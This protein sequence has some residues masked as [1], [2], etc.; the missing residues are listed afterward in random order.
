MRS[1]A[2]H[3]AWLKVHY[4]AEFMA[5][6]L[7]A[8]QDD[9]D[10]VKILIEDARKILEL[11]I[12]PPDVMLSNYHFTPVLESG[13]VAGSRGCATVLV[14]LRGRGTVPSR[15]SSRPRQS[16]PFRDLYD[17]CRRIDKRVVNRRV[18]EAL[19]R[20]GSFDTI[21]KDR[22]SLLA[23]VP[24]A[25]EAAEQ[26]EANLNQ[27]SLFDMLADGKDDAFELIRVRGFTEKQQLTEEKSALGLLPVRP[28]L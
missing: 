10:K 23:S 24:R 27:V 16:E 18:L 15:R 3:T 12:L 19:I 4:P 9:T 1:L 8:A 20:A 2:Y 25:M 13:P 28:S 21:E 26:A 17:F 22:A 6:N 5:A 14:P 7:S 11:E